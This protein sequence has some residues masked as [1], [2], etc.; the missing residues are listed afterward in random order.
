MVPA[1]RNALLGLTGFAVT[2]PAL[3]FAPRVVAVPPAAAVRDLC[4]TSSGEIRH[5]GWE[6]KDGRRQRVYIASTDGGESWRTVVADSDDVGAMVRSPYGGGWIYWREDSSRQLECVRSQS[7]P[8]DVRPTVVRFPWKGLELRQ[9]VALKSKPRWIACFSDAT[10][11]EGRCYATALLLSDDDGRTWRRVDVSPVPNVSRLA[12]GDRRPHWYCDGG[13]PSLV[14]LT[15]GTLLMAVR[16]SGPNA[17]FYRSRDGGETWSEGEPDAAFWQANTM[18]YLFRLKDGRLLFVWNNTQM[19]PTREATEYPELTEDELGGRWESVFTNRDALHAAISEDDG[20]TWIGFREVALSSNRNDADFREQGNALADE[21]DKSVHQTQAIERPDGTVLLA[22]GQNSS[23]RRIVVLDP[24]WLYETDRHEDFRNGLGGVSTHLYVRS[25][26]GG[27]R[28]WAGHC[29]WNR[30]SGP[31]L[32]RE[33]DTNPNSV[34]EALQLCHIVDPRLVSDRQGVVWNFPASRQG[35]FETECRI[36]GEGFQ[37][38]LTDHWINPCDE[39]NPRLSPVV[40]RVTPDMTGRGKW[41][42][43]RCTWDF[44]SGRADLV[45][46]GKVLSKLQVRT[47]PRFGLS[48]VHLQTLATDS[49]VKGA[50]FRSFDKTLK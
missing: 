38:A 45:C 48:Y 11:P 29:A 23:V 9:L 27:Y 46:D 10:C 37:L 20:K 19:L 12:P 40:F 14:E 5:Y 2:S 8:G 31:L 43:L 3:G 18:P 26:T 13:E 47:R 6:A 33:P 4:V 17:A 25:L 50:F 16:S 15:D 36:E 41:V 28:G 34:R 35:A 42:R 21:H 1:V 24:S 44:E 32:V 49:D 22:L 39:T 30:V 7:G